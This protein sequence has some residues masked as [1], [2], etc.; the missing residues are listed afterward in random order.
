VLVE[1]PLV[2]GGL[3]DEIAAQQGGALAADPTT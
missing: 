2:G 1:Q 3:G